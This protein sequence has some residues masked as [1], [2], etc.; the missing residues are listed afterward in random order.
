[1]EPTNH[2]F[3][4]EN[5]L[6]NLHDEMFQQLI[7]RGVMI[8]E[9]NFNVSHHTLSIWP[10]ELKRGVFSPNGSSKGVV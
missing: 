4:K 3:R 6:P 10:F 2:P 7:F 9:V 1:M 5:D 8:S